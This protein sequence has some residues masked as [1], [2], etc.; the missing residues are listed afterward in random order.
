MLCRSNPTV[1]SNPTL[2][3]NGVQ[4]KTT[5]DVW[6]E[7]RISTALAVFNLV[8]LGINTL[9]LYLALFFL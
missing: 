8:L 1:G 2:S 7:V 5:D 6:Y 3:V 4:M 9:M